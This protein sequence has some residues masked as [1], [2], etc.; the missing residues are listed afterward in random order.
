MANILDI[1]R[2]H[3]GDRIL[4]RGEELTGLKKDELLKTHQVLF[5]LLLGVMRS[6]KE[7]EKPEMEKLISYIEK[8]DLIKDGTRLSGTLYSSDEFDSIASLGKIIKVNSEN[9]IKGVYISTAILSAIVNGIMENNSQAKFSEVIGT[10]LGETSKFDKSFIQLLVKN[11]DSP[12]LINSSEEIALN[13][14]SNDDD[15]SI[16]GGFTGGK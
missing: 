6:K 5:P 11:S 4:E 3:T 2:T 8:E 9:F 14:E 7:I 16:L 10:L 13:P 15:E 12:N 1:F